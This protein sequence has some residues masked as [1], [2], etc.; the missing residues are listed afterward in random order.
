MPALRIAGLLAQLRDRPVGDLVDDRACQC[1]ERLLL[2]R[3]QRPQ[4]APH[5]L[6]L[7]YPNLLQLLAQA[8]PTPCASRKDGEARQARLL[9]VVGANL[10]RGTVRRRHGG[11]L[12]QHFIFERR[13]LILQAGGSFL[14]SPPRLRAQSAHSLFVT[15][16]LDPAVHGDRKVCMDCRAKGASMPVFNGYARQ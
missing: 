12:R 2:L 6:D 4:L 5:L 16:G 11:K 9:V 7:G 3:R 1:I 10:T 8:K 13:H 14:D 15:T